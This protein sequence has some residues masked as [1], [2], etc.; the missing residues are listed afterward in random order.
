MTRGAIKYKPKQSNAPQEATTKKKKSKTG[1]LTDQPVE[2]FPS[3]PEWVTDRDSNATTPIFFWKPEGAWGFLGQWYSSP[4]RSPLP[5]DC[6]DGPDCE[7]CEAERKRFSCCEQY[8][9][10]TSP[11][12][13]FNP[14]LLPDP[15][16]HA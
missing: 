1:S 6:H 16:Q 7:Q 5:T 9:R 3:T 8:V 14:T 13:T 12:L 11:R 10:P 2:S 15:S 4:F